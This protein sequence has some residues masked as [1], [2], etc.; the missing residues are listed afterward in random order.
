LAGC[1]PWSSDAAYGVAPART[2]Q[3]ESARTDNERRAV[4]TRSTIA[5]IPCP[6]PMHIV[7]K[8]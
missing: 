2:G 7:H 4:Q 6:T 8:A 3:N 5:A 1:F